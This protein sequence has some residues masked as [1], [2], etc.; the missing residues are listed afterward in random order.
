[1]RL[2][3]YKPSFLSLAF[4]IGII[5]YA[6]YQLIRWNRSLLGIALFV[7]KFPWVFVAA[8]VLGGALPIILTFTLKI[9]T[10]EYFLPRLL[11]YIGTAAAIGISQ[12]FVTIPQGGLVILTAVSSAIT[13]LYFYQFHKTRFSEWC[14]IFLST[15]QIYMM[16]YYLLW[17]HDIQNA[18][19]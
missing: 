5:I 4:P 14:V 1:M 2:F 18:I 7:F 6:G 10:R 8:I 12:E 11:M 13:M 19:G 16:A 9:E 15:P 3:K 17:D